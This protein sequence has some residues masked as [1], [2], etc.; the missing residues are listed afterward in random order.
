[1]RLA[2]LKRKSYAKEICEYGIAI[3]CNRCLCNM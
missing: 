2:C 1:L 3:L